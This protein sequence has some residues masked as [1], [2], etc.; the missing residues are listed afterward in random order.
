MYKL[1][2]KQMKKKKYL[3]KLI[4]GRVMEG[5]S[6]RTPIFYHGNSFKNLEGEVPAKSV[7]NETL[8]YRTYPYIHHPQACLMIKHYKESNYYVVEIKH[9][10]I[11]KRFPRVW[12]MYITKE[13]YLSSLKV[14][15]YYETLE[16]A[17]YYANKFSKEFPLMPKYIK[18]NEDLKKLNVKQWKIIK[19]VVNA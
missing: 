12:N 6:A 16:D 5:L 13:S 18:P 7:F 17:E 4:K 8:K 10:N 9:F 3:T 11:L 2:G 14:F 19:V 15:S 1:K